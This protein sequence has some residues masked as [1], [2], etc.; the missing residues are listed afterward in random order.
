M[1]H[2]SDEPLREVIAGIQSRYDRLVGQYTA[3]ITERD[4]LL[5]WKT[6]IEPLA[7][8]VAAADSQGCVASCHGDSSDIQRASERMGRG[9]C[10]LRI[11]LE[12][13]DGKR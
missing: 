5:A 10:K 12:T 13:L 3:V 9:A 4:N 11:A 8:E 1:T 6:T 2:R 7:R